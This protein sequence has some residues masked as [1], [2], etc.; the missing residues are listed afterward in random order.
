MKGKK[1]NEREKI[2]Q[3]HHHQ[4]STLDD[5][6]PETEK[7][8]LVQ[9]SQRRLSGPGPPGDANHKTN[10]GGS[11]DAEDHVDDDARPSFS[12]D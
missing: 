9:G 12:L 7:M 1:R 2:G 5:R 3:G 4:V 10:E 8:E 11:E 6:G